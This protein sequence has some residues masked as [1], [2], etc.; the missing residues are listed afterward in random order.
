MSDEETETVF[1][2]IRWASNGGNPFCPKDAGKLTRQEPGVSATPSSNGFAV[3]LV[4]LSSYGDRSFESPSLQ[5]RVQCEP[6]AD[7]F[8]AAGGAVLAEP[9]ADRPQHEMSAQPVLCRPL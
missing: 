4:G 8:L 6:D 9:L 3:S 5:R 2:K 1:R 7:D